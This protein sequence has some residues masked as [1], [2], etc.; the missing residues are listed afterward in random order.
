MARGDKDYI[1]IK[2]VIEQKK[3]TKT[4][5]KQLQKLG[6]SQL[7]KMIVSGESLEEVRGY[8]RD[9]KKLER[10]PTKINK[11]TASNIAKAWKGQNLTR[12]AGSWGVYKSKLKTP[13]AKNIKAAGYLSPQTIAAIARRVRDK[14]FIGRL[15]KANEVYLQEVKKRHEDLQ[16]KKLK[17]SE[18]IA[19]AK[20]ENQTIAG[21]NTIKELALSHAVVGPIITNMGGWEAANQRYPGEVERLINDYIL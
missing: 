18:A 10:I 3:P 19:L 11:R 9:L 5:V 17:R 13:K 6:A 2:W 14:S 7:K 16:G 21:E 1:N 15:K 4:Q 20:V 8:M 12:V